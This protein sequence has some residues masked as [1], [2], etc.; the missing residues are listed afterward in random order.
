MKVYDYQFLNMSL[1]KKNHSLIRFVEKK[2]KI[3][4]KYKMKNF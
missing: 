4:I 2:I 1:E 3:K